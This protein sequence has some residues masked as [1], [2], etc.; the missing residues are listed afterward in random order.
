MNLNRARKPFVRKVLITNPVGGEAE[1]SARAIAVAEDA[2][3]TQGF[4]PQAF[5]AFAATIGPDGPAGRHPGAFHALIPD[6]VNDAAVAFPFYNP[7][8]GT[9]ERLRRSVR[10]WVTGGGS[11]D[12]DN[13][14]TTVVIGSASWPG[15]SRARIDPEV[16]GGPADLMTFTN[17]II[18]IGQKLFGPITFGIQTTLDTA[19]PGAPWTLKIS[20]EKK[21]PLGAWGPLETLFQQQ[22]GNLPNATGCFDTVPIDHIDGTQYRFVGERL[23]GPAGNEEIDLRSTAITVDME[24]DGAVP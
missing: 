22:V 24:I 18:D 9:L 16:T 14:G 19:S 23:G 6:G 1:D 4:D 15:F 20:V 7:G 2:I 3:D 13:L 17:G 21:P 10:M 11:A 8:T 12:L 5:Q